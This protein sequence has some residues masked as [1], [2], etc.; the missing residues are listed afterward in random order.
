MFR[1]RWIGSDYIVDAVSPCWS[2]NTVQA[3]KRK[4]DY[5]SDNSNGVDGGLFMINTYFQATRITKLGGKELA[6]NFS[7]SRNSKDPCN[8]KKLTWLHNLDNQIL[9]VKDIYKEQGFT[10]WVAYNDHVKPYL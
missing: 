1:F 10:P 5:A 3:I 7:D 2:T 8:K 6:C 4:C 9:I